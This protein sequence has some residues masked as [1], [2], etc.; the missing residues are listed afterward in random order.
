MAFDNV[1]SQ[2]RDNNIVFKTTDVCKMVANT[3]APCFYVSLEQALL[4][5]RLY[6]QG[7]SNIRSDVRRQ[8]FAVIFMRFE[9]LMKSANGGLYKYAAM[10][11]V[12]EQPAPS[13]YLTDTSSVLFY[14]NARK[15]KR[16][17]AVKIC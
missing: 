9:S 8:M 4:Q 1:V 16:K 10:S 7:K 15:K 3:A 17:K 14:Y 12:L 13:F 6:K 5:Y 11:S 2:L